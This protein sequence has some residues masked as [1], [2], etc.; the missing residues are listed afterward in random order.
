ME[1]IRS[2]PLPWRVKWQIIWLFS[3]KVA[4]SACAL[5]QDA[6]GRFLVLGSRYS[7]AWQLPGG[8]VDRGET[9]EEAVRRECR[10]ELGC[11]LQTIRLTAIV[12]VL[13]GRTQIALYDAELAPGPIRLSDEHTALRYLRREELPAHLRRMIE[14]SEV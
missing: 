7:G 8:G 9:V 12:P 2:T 4:L 6:S 14:A 3:A 13:H 5:I 1:T 10:E 11:E